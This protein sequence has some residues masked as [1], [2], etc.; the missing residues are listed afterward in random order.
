MRKLPFVVM[1]IL[2]LGGVIMSQQ[3]PIYGLPP[4]SPQPQQPPV[5][6]QPPGGPAPAPPAPNPPVSPRQPPVGG[7][8]GFV[9]NSKT[10]VQTAR[11]VKEYLSAGKAWAVRGPGGEV[12]LKGGIV[13]QGIVI[14]TVRFDPLSG[15]VL[16]EGYHARVY[17][18]R[19]SPESL[20]SRLQDVISKIEVVD[21]ASYREPEACW[22]I[23]LVYDSMIIAHIKIYTDGIHVIP[24]YVADRE[25]KWFGTGF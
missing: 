10:A 11:E 25:M 8:T 22:V 6:P 7:Y 2:V 12:E 20:V 5:S 14:A 1:T 3:P 19:V 23:P 17:E 9:Q 24:D 16:P 15:E 13:Y 4:A 21:G 18:L